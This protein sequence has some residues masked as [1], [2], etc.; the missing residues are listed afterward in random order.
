[1]FPSDVIQIHI[2]LYPL[3]TCPHHSSNHF[4][5][6]SLLSVAAVS[7][8]PLPH[9]FQVRCT[10]YIALHSFFQY[11]A[12]VCR[13]PNRASKQASKQAIF[14]TSNPSKNYERQ[15]SNLF[16]RPASQTGKQ[17][18][19]L[20]PLL[21]ASAVTEQSKHRGGHGEGENVLGFVVWR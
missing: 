6:P 19:L 20:P 21:A 5:P 3:S 10:D 8:Q 13:L 9:H 4:L 7:F 1:M 11:Q 18:P 17:S 12:T 2:F 14:S 16:L 15:T